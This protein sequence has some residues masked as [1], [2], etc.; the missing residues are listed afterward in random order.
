MKKIMICSI[1][2]ISIITYFIISY[3]NEEIMQVSNI[4][5]NL[6]DIA[7]YLQTE[8]GS[9]E[10]DSVDTIPSKDDGYV[11]KEAVCNDSSVVLFNNNSWSLNVNNMENGRVRCKLYFDIDDAIARTYIL[12]QNTVNEETPDFSTTATTDEGIFMIV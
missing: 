10:Y 7:F 5:N 4:D 9:E 11:F 3:D 2:C 12:S 1:I 8:E 6:N